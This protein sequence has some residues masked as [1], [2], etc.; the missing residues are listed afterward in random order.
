MLIAKSSN[1]E[2]LI[3]NGAICLGTFD[4]LQFVDK[5]LHGGIDFAKYV[6]M[7]RMDV[8]THTTTIS[9]EEANEHGLKPVFDLHAAL[10]DLWYVPR[11]YTMK[12]PNIYANPYIF[13]EEFIN[14]GL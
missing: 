2:Q 8:Y 12:L 7:A 13:S 9:T 4:N 1:R 5:I 14:S 10:I 3:A 6:Q 11:E